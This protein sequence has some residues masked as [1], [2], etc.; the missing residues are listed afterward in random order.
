M[1]CYFYII[2]LFIVM[3]KLILWNNVYAF[4]SGGNFYY[5]NTGIRDIC[6]ENIDRD[7]QILKTIGPIHRVQ[8]KISTI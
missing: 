5:L 4:S 6:L 3:R 1:Q 8:Q 2:S 7:P